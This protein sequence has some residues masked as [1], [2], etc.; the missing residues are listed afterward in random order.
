MPEAFSLFPSNSNTPAGDRRKVLI[1]GAGGNIG[2]YFCEHNQGRYDLRL[3]VHS[4]DERKG[5]ESFGDTVQLDITD[6]SSLQSA[7][8][9]IHTVVHLAGDPSPTADWASLLPVN[10]VG[11]YNTFV[12]ARDAG[13]R[14]VIFASS[15]HAISGYPEDVQVKSN[16]PVNPGDLYGVSKCFGEALARYFAEQEGVSAIA[17]RIGGFQPRSVAKGETGVQMLDAWVSQRDLFQLICRCID[18]DHL[19]F[20]IFSGLS[21]NRF[22]RMDIDDARQLVG[23]APVDDSTEINQELAALN[24]GDRVSSHSV[25]DGAP[26]GAKPQNV[27]VIPQ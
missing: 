23:Y 12:A 6:L 25:A 5:I 22:K 9:D 4:P 13:C 14:R 19:K 2:R 21:D 8:K 10:I 3:G 18:A 16:D 11:T 15:I 20:A 24:L 26:S 1:S 27:K 7:C 17:L